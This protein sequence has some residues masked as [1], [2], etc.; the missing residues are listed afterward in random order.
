MLL[1]HI[2]VISCGGHLFGETFGQWWYKEY[3]SVLEFGR[4]V[5]DEM[6]FKDFY[7]FGSFGHLV[8]MKCCFKDISYFNF[9]TFGWI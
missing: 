4:A 5:Q 6:S 1:K 7:M 3:L 8:R 2:S 9:G